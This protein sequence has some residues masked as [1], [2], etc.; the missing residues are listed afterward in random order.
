MSS[1]PRRRELSPTARRQPFYCSRSSS[2]NIAPTQINGVLP[3]SC[4]RHRQP[5]LLGFEICFRFLKVPS[6]MS[7]S[8]PRPPTASP[9]CFKP[10]RRRRAVPYSSSSPLLLFSKKLSNIERTQID[11][12]LLSSVIDIVNQRWSFSKIASGFEGTIIASHQVVRAKSHEAT[13][14]STTPACLSS[15][16]RRQELSPTAR[17]QPSCCSQRS[18]PTLLQPRSTEIG[19][20]SC[21]ERV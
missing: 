1:R 10:V 11:G 5:K 4:D 18:S 14:K 2:P 19:R 3:S 8:Q 16:P 9:A 13:S 21:R 6:L 17:R 7:S 20:A 12:V 15:R